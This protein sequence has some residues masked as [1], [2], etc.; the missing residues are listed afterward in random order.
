MVFPTIGAS[1]GLECG[2]SRDSFSPRPQ[3]QVATIQSTLKVSRFHSFSLR[4]VNLGT[5]LLL[6]KVCLTKIALEGVESLSDEEI[7]VLFLCWTGLQS[8]RD[9]TWSQ[10]FA[11]WYIQ[12]SSTIDLL[13]RCF[14]DRR[15]VQPS[16]VQ[17]MCQ[18]LR[19][20]EFLLSSHAYFGWTELFEVKSFL[21]LTNRQWKQD[22]TRPKRYIGVGYKD[23][24]TKRDSA[25]DGS[26]SWQE[27]ASTGEYTESSRSI[28][29]DPDLHY[30]SYLPGMFVT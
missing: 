4:N 25:F 7:A 28:V 29:H 17:E 24:G 10:Y 16:W 20:R 14:N 15:K 8:V 27:V 19:E 21:R 26:P 12:V 13:A 30:L 22:R 6:V 18:F 3:I 1:S 11:S 2:P 5:R 23:S 9:P